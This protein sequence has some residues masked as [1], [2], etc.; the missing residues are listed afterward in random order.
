M[1]IIRLLLLLYFIIIYY[2]LLLLL[3]LFFNGQS[4]ISLIST[5]S[6][7]DRPEQEKHSTYFINFKKLGSKT[8]RQ[9]RRHQ[10]K[11]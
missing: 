8:N 4:M 5:L 2:Y 1:T 10:Q 9:L 3:L 7:R 11:K 6:A